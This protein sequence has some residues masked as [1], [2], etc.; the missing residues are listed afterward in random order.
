MKKIILLFIAS[1][2]LNSCVVSTAA[3]VVKATTKVAY[4]GVKGT[5]KGV[6]WVVKKA[7]GKIN[8][9]RMDGTWKLVGIYNGSYENFQKDE[10]PDN[11][12]S[13]EC[14]E[15]FESIVFNTKRHRFQPIHCNKEKE[16]WVDYDYEFGKNPITKEKEN[17]FKYGANNYVTL[18][19]IS[20]NT[21]VLEGSLVPAYSFSGAKVYLFEKAR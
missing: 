10:A 17:Y 11:S 16:E 3:K 18:V 8:E 9:D 21:M 12:F 5:V 20:G 15:D 6:S 4:K 14:G 2:L 7:K 1:F 19:N 13:S